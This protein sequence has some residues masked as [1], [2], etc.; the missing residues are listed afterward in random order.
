MKNN[1]TSLKPTVRLVNAKEPEF[2]ARRINYHYRERVQN[3]W[4][5]K[6]V[7]HGRNPDGNSIMLVSND[8][9]S[10]AGHP[11]VLSAQS[12]ALMGTG[13]GL[14]MS[15]VFLKGEN[16]QQRFERRLANFMGAEDGILCQSGWCANTGLIQS[17][18]DDRTP[19]YVDMFAH[20]SIWEG[21]R[22]AGA[23]AVPFH[24][25]DP[26]HLERQVL[27]HGPGIIAV[28]SV[29]ST[30]GAVC[31]LEEVVE[32]ATRHGCVL[33]VDE[34]HSLGT[35]GVHGEGLVASLGLNDRVHFCTASLAKAFAGRAGFVTCS[36]RFREYFVFESR[37]FIF[38]SAMLPHEIAG[39]EETLTII[40]R[41]DWR[42]QA[43][44]ENTVYLRERLLGLGYNVTNGQAQIISLESGSEPQTIVLREALEDRGIFGAVFCAPA[45]PKNRA[46]VRLSVQAAMT[47]DELDRVVEVCREIRDEVGVSNWA[48]T[49]RMRNT[50]PAVATC[51]PLN[52]HLASA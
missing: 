28:D 24:H 5:G 17:I 32:V 50:P 7:L 18:A 8:Y 11:Q 51:A 35:H 16:P 46:L 22:S 36:R 13:D 41:D 34:S 38:S 44:R 6:H 29:Y 31:P 33:V 37:P 52:T 12:E 42:R 23:R 21:I 49:R 3:T 14:L 25:N 40:G 20:M 27:K 2:L 47:R 9:L 10:L 45:T 43:L 30:S 1:V 15:P 26:V 4:G 48:S 39:L 19:V